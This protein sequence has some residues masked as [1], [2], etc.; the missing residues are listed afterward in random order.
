M[1]IG[2]IGRK[3]HG[4]DTIGDHLASA[5]FKKI[6]F[7]NRVKSVTVRLFPGLSHAQLYGPNELKEAVDVN[8]GVS[9]RWLLQKVGTEIGRNGHLDTLEC[10]GVSSEKVALALQEFGVTTGPTAWIDSLLPARSSGKYVITDTRFPN[11]AQFTLDKGGLVLKVVRPGYDTGHHNDH[12]SET[13][14]DK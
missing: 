10:L 5:G 6:A 3:Q 9:P 1:L 11:E 2:V 12:P 8:I 7:A 4:K 14:V 13:D